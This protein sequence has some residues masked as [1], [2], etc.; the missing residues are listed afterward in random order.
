M[1]P[2]WT[3]RQ[4]LGVS[5]PSGR[6]LDVIAPAWAEIGKA[7]APAACMSLRRE[8]LVF[9]VE[10]S[11]HRHLSSLASWIAI[12]APGGMAGTC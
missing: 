5:V 4:I 11:C 8:N 10:G 2:P 3:S 9:M 7:T 12:Q 1:S 6:G